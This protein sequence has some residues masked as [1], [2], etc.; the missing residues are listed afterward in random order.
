MSVPTSGNSGSLQAEVIDVK[1]DINDDD[2]DVISQTY[3]F[4][5][6]RP[7]LWVD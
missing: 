7:F 3:Q 4:L 5:T 2:E 6:K 1:I